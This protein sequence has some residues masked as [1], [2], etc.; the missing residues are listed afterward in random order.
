MRGAGLLVGA[1]AAGLSVLPGTPRAAAALVCLAQLCALAVLVARPRGIDDEVST[2]RWWSLAV[3]VLTVS[4]VVDLLPGAG[5][6]HAL[7][8]AVVAATP[9]VYGALVRWNRFRTYVSDPGDWLNG[10]SAISALTAATLVLN[11]WFVLLPPTWS[12]WRIHL[13]LLVFASVVIL[14]GT[15]ATVCSIG[16]LIRDPRSWLVI[17][18]LAGLAVLSAT[19]RGGPHDLTRA[20]LGWTLA[21]LAVAGASA[22]RSRTRPVP[23][24]SQAPAVGALVVLALAVAVLAL[25]G[26]RQGWAPTAYAAAA[27]AGISVRVVRL[28]RELAHLAESRRQALTDELTGAGNRRALLQALDLVVESRRAAALLLIDVDRFKEV[29]D[30][31]GHHAGD[32]LLRRIVTAVRKTTPADAVVT[33]IGG[34]E[35]AV[36]L[37]GRDEAQATTIGHAVHD[38]VVHFAE[39]GLSVGVRSA[40]AGAVDPDRL[41]QQADTAMYAAK[42][43]GGGVSVYD[44]EVDAG[45]RDRAALA[46]DVRRLLTGD[47][48]RVE[49]EVVVHYQPQVD[50]VTGRVVGVEALVR[51]QHP[52][53]GLLPPLVFLDLVEEQGLMERLTVHVLRRATREAAGWQHDGVPLRIS[54]NLSASSLT[55]PDLLPVVDDLLAATGLVPGRLV[56]EVTETT[57]MADPDLALAVTHGLTRRGVQLSID[58][59]GT[60]YS[61]LAYLTDLPATELKLDRAFT[62]RVLAEPRTAQIVEATV[63]LAHRLGLR[64]VAEGVEDEATRAVLGGLDVDETQGY[65]HSRPLPPADLARWL[66]ALPPPA[67]FVRAE[68]REV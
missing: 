62:A 39:V 66:A 35:F 24:T 53:R 9:L 61:S 16:G 8:L 26:G 21:S 1:A 5:T 3:G 56:L 23:A 36:L 27:V 29:N 33:R 64:V 34:D 57:L 30:R 42:T 54:V 49:R 2:W 19:V 22:L 14:L 38:A 13:T 40:P 58:D 68:F 50:V 45:L 4:P 10:L 6:G 47:G 41:L 31:Q 12:A 32:A 37:P 46:A 60:G 55:H 51:W 63:A 11:R 43:S 65:L 7:G 18:T 20:Q 15:A 25:D 17:A 28:V 52:D 44:S 48:H 67:Q 59:Y